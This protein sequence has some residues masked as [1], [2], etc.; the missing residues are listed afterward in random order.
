[1]P[2]RA[3]VDVAGAFHHVTNRGNHGGEIFR[4]DVDRADFLDQLAAATARQ[5]WRCHGYCLMDDHF[6]LLLE[7][8]EANLARGMQW[9]AAVVT[10]RFNRH[11]GLVGHLFQ[12]RY[13]AVLIQRQSHLLEA[14]R[15]IAL[16]PV[17]ATMV[18][19]AGDW[20]WSHHRAFAGLA[21]APPWLTSGWF[22]DQLGSDETAAQAAYRSF[23][24]EGRGQTQEQMTPWLQ[25]RRRG[26]PW[27]RKAGGPDLAA[28]AAS[29]QPAGDWMRQAQAEGY[30]QT[31]IARAAGLSQASVNR[32][33]RTP[34]E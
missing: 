6:H 11:H 3:R 20:P 14:L 15:Y 13:H 25:A 27:G 10:Q 4:D 7:T 18:V 32:R 16:N 21:P 2:R 8:P 24:A 33:L 31:A 23:I 19:E 1:M 12:G 26:R 9:L 34:S 28:L 22:W 30:S 5:G 29:G 17:R